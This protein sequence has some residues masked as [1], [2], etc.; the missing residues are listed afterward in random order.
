MKSIFKKNQIIIAALA[1]MIMVAGYLNF[2][3]DNIDD[4]TSDQAVNSTTVDKNTA[5]SEGNDIFADISDENATAETEFIT[6]DDSQALVVDENSDA[7]EASPDATD[8]AT[9]ETAT[10]NTEE[11]AS[12]EG[13]ATS[14]GEAILASTTL[15]SSYFSTAKL[16]RE[17]TRAKNKELLM[18]VIT[19]ANVSDEQKQ[20]ALDEIVEMTDIADKENA[21][22][23]LLE[24]K[25]FD[26][27]VVS[28]IDGTVDVVVNSETITDAQ[29][30]QI[31][32]IVTRKTGA[33]V[34]DIVIT[35]VI[36]EE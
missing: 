8:S 31:E 25:G 26:G 18:S 32:D 21:A 14:P 20:A 15:N 35:S 33:D 13:E 24:A 23:I 29:V 30:A 17:Q 16:T 7:A 19:D 22:E 10:T 2:T 36:I 27:A 6:V 3:K 1:I 5:E 4:P 9:N 12:S 34:D 28:I 11:Q